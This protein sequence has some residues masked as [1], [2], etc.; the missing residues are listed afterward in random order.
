NSFRGNPTSTPGCSGTDTLYYIDVGALTNGLDDI[1]VRHPLAE[2]L[3]SCSH[4]LGPDA[5]GHLWVKDQPPQ[6]QGG[7]WH[8]LDVKATPADPS[9]DEWAAWTSDDAPSFSEQSAAVDPAHGL[10]I[11]DYLYSYGASL[12][13]ADDDSWSQLGA[14]SPR[15]LALDSQGGRWFG[16]LAPLLRYL[17]DGGTPE[18]AADDRWVEYSP[19]DGLPVE[20]IRDVQVDAFDRLWLMGNRWDD[21]PQL[22]RL[23][24]SG[25][26]LDK[27]DDT[28]S[29]YTTSDGLN[30][31][32]VTAMAVAPI[33]NVWVGTAK[34][35]QCL[36]LEP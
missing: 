26:P 13:D 28:W 22:C 34:G 12:S 33:G 29:C 9:D 27:S 14:A 6:S 4:L 30:D 21:E 24:P 17:D 36:E 1:W 18:L 15:S 31:P 16:Y 32:E 20:Y 7:A 5:S 25:T 3:S 19:A 2:V 8:L 11:G 23:D 35:L 10:W